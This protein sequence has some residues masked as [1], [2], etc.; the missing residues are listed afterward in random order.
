[1]PRRPTACS[2]GAEGDPALRVAS[3]GAWRSRGAASARGRAGGRLGRM[4]ASSRRGCRLRPPLAGR[5]PAPGSRLSGWARAG[6][7]CRR[8][9]APRRSG[10]CR[11][12]AVADAEHVVGGLPLFCGCRTSSAAPSTRWKSSRRKSR[13]RPAAPRPGGA[14]GA[15]RASRVRHRAWASSS[16]TETGVLSFCSASMATRLSVVERPSPAPPRARLGSAL[17]RRASE[18]VA[19]ASGSCF[20]VSMAQSVMCAARCEA[21]SRLWA[22]AAAPWSCWATARSRAWLSHALRLA[23]NG[24]IHPAMASVS[25]ETSGARATRSSKPGARAASGCPLLRRGCRMLGVEACATVGEEPT[26]SPFERRAHRRG[27]PGMAGWARPR[28]PRSRARARARRRPLLRPS[29][30]ADGQ[31]LLR[32]CPRLAFASSAASLFRRDR[33]RAVGRGAR[34]AREVKAAEISTTRR[35]DGLLCSSVNR[36]RNRPS[37]ATAA[38]HTLT[39]TR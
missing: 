5:W 8:P 27:S 34:R 14:R 29:V 11:A 35:P 30:P 12:M 20:I 25:A 7:P 17:R 9:R 4:G 6:S 36:I 37:S 26:S 15:A 2:P 1:M 19:D 22:K 21:T 13:G 28:A 23:P 33:R 3:P 24:E 10:R 31:T 32:P 39:A 16:S 18:S 38:L